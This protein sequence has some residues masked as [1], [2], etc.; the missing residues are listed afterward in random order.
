MDGVKRA[1]SVIFNGISEQYKSAV[2]GLKNQLSSRSLSLSGLQK[3]VGGGARQD[4]DLVVARIALLHLCLPR[5]AHNEGPA[6]AGVRR[7]RS[8]C[9]CLFRGV[10]V[11][12]P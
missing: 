8:R 10:A 1:P 4:D 12:A 7:G 5:L 9:C 6:E 2:S 3:Q 11:A